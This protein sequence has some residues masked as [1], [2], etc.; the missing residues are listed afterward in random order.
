VNWEAMGAIG[1]VLGATGV[2]LSLLYLAV[3]IRGDARAKRASAVHE[4]SDAYRDFLKTLASDEELAAIYLRGIRDFGSIEE[5]ELVRFSSALGF[6]FRVFDEAF[7]QWKE[8]HLDARLW[9]GFESPMA[10][11]LA[12]PG[13][14]D[15]WSTRSSWY[16]TPF[17]ELIQSK[18]SEI[19]APVLYGEVAARQHFAADS[20]Q[21]D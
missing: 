2:I 21:R 6:L 4:Q 11:M 9:R 7:F 13:V 19:G 12:Y 14:R 17:Q 5:A 15:W 1:E 20:L 10:D 8:G 3:Q 16:S 18:I